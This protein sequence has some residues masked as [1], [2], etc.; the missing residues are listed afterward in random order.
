MLSV[1]YAECLKQTHYAECHYAECRYAKCHFAEIHGALNPAL[2]NVRGA[3]VNRALDG[4]TC[5][6]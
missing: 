6:G 3:A 5:P 2:Y 1:V 4:S